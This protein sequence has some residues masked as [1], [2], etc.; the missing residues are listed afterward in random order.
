MEIN[1]AKNFITTEKIDLSRFFGGE[2]AFI[3]IREPA[4]IELL[5]LTKAYQGDENKSAEYVGKL[6]PDLIIEH[7]FTDNTKKVNSKKVV[8]IIDSITSCWQYVYNELTKVLPLN[9]EENE[10]DK[11]K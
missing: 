5:D 3:V 2:E 10:E 4:K 9:D 11:K 7:N 8:E 6:L 1:T